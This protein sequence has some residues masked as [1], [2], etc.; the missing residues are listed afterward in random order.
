MWQ[1]CRLDTEGENAFS[2]GWSPCI[3]RSQHLEG[4]L[5]K[6]TYCA[7]RVQTD[8]WRPACEFRSLVPLNV[9]FFSMQLAGSYSKVASKDQSQSQSL[10]HSCLCHSVYADINEVHFIWPD[11]HVFCLL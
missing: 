3:H 2:R 7:P 4:L 11:I 10:E 5:V 8:L 6:I 9:S 1:L